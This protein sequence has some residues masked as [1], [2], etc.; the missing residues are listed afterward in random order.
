M[1]SHCRIC[2]NNNVELALKIHP[3]VQYEVH[4]GHS[5]LCL[6]IGSSS[7]KHCVSDKVPGYWDVLFFALWPTALV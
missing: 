5:T 4:L 1:G 6:S 3:T 7:A 2:I